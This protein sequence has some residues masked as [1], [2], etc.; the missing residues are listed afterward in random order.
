MARVLVCGVYL[1]DRDNLARSEMV[2]LAASAR[3]QVTQR[4]IALD[5]NGNGVCGLPHTVA[6]VKVQ[7]PKFSLVN[8]LIEDV[9]DFDRL[10]VCDDDVQFPARFLDDFLALVDEFAFAISQPARTPDSYID[11]FITT[12][13]PGLRGRQT[14]FV[15]IGPVTCIDRSAYPVLLPFDRRS[16]MGWG[17][18]FVWPV[19][20][21]RGGLR[22]GIV[23]ATPI[24]HSLRQARANYPDLPVEEQMKDLL[25]HNLS[26][27]PLQAFTIVE[28]YA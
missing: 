2:E 16:P 24:S 22:M 15:E 14:R 9:Q 19:L 11:H 27:T 8:G 20:A 25:G 28:A 10:I 26:L 13:M 3:H 17:L 5:I 23:D 1:A 4:W 21:E 18:D 6:T 12:R 7:T